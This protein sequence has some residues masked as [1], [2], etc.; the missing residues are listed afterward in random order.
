M[1]TFRIFRSDLTMF[2]ER[3][4]EGVRIDGYDYELDDEYVYEQG[5][6]VF[7]LDWKTNTILPTQTDLTD[8]WE[9]TV[10]GVKYNVHGKTA[11]PPVY[12]DGEY[13]GVLESYYDKIT[14]E[15]KYMVVK[16]ECKIRYL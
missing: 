12:K 14:K 11:F 1:A 7:T 6:H 8:T 10:D 13:Y 16:N 4:Y 9:L 5:Y 15:R 2:V 3:T